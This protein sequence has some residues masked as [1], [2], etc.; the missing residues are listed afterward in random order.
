MWNRWMRNALSFFWLKFSS[1][2]LTR[3][4]FYPLTHQ[5]SPPTNKTGKKWDLFMKNLNHI[6]CEFSHHPGSKR[7]K[8]IFAWLSITKKKCKRAQKRRNRKKKKKG[9]KGFTWKFVRTTQKKTKKRPF[10][11]SST[12]SH[13]FYSDNTLN[14]FF[15]FPH[16]DFIALNFS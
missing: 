1:Q 16:F 13:S 7:E 10:S 15:N 6:F 3:L 11:H 12:V 4:N 8:N 5:Q 9:C 2:M 14:S